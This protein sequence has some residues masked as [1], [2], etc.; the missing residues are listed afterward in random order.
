MSKKSKRED[1]EATQGN[2]DASDTVEV[3]KVPT[4]DMMPSTVF[5]ALRDEIEEEMTYCEPHEQRL[6]ALLMLVL[7]DLDGR[8]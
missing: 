2:A 7:T 1:R 3:G 4:E 5:K 8:V 6:L